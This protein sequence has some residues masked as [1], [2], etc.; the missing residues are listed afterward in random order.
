[1]EEVVAFV[2]ERR[3]LPWVAQGIFFF[4]RPLP[5]CPFS[6]SSHWFPCLLFGV[7]C[8]SF[9]S[10]LETLDVLLRLVSLGWLLMLSVMLLVS[11]LLQLV[12]LESMLLVPVSEL[13]VVLVLLLLL[14]LVV[15]VGP[16]FVFE[17]GMMMDFFPLF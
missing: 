5:H 6:L 4:W 15:M 8:F 17:E 10:F 9:C 14:L 3:G 13:L 12:L 7:V 16:L 1:M 2:T 11:E